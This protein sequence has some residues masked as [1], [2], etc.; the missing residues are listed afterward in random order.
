MLLYFSFDI[1][2]WISLLLYFRSLFDNLL[3]I[4]FYSI[5]F[6]VHLLVIIDSCRPVSASPRRAD[7]WV[8]L[9]AGDRTSTTEPA[10]KLSLVFDSVMLWAARMS[11]NVVILKRNRQ[12]VLEIE[13]STRLSFYRIGS[14][15]KESH[16][17]I[18]NPHGIGLCNYPENNYFDISFCSFFSLYIISLM[19][20]FYK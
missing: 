17:R 14:R 7:M 1:R 15:N 12:T 5:S 16:D 13:K 8:Y 19:V 9:Y 11:K 10:C 2:Y 4:I 20:N 6:L 18:W 3:L